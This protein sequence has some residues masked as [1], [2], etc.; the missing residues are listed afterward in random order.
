MKV[1]I[2]LELFEIWVRNKTTLNKWK[3]NNFVWELTEWSSFEAFCTCALGHPPCFRFHLPFIRRCP[4][5]ALVC[6]PFDLIVRMDFVVASSLLS[7]LADPARHLNQGASFP[8]WIASRHLPQ[9]SDFSSTSSILCYIAATLDCYGLFLYLFSFS[10]TFRL[11]VILS[12]PLACR[13]TFIRSI[14]FLVASFAFQAWFRLCFHHLSIA[15]Y[16]ERDQGSTFVAKP[17]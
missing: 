1:E 10:T 13:R 11:P 5:L 3:V 14:P 8:T 7:Y 16:Q 12:H 15:G 17:C 4:L 6:D 9:S 2:I